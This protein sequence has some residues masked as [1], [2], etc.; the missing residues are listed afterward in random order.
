[1]YIYIIYIYAYYRNTFTHTHTHRHIYIHTHTCTYIDI[2]TYI[3]PVGYCT[4]KLATPKDRRRVYV[5][6]LQATKGLQRC[7]SEFGVEDVGLKG[8]SC[9]LV[10]FLIG[11][12]L[13][14]MGPCLLLPSSSQVF[15]SPQTFTRP[16]G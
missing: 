3:A 4:I 12:E 16:A 1:M 14:R 5:G 10:G 11:A 2:H 13:E 9:A 6:S 7:F 8:I 15:S